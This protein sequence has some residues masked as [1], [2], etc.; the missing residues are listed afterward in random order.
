MNSRDYKAF[1]SGFW[2]HIYNRGHNKGLIFMDRQDYIAF[3]KRLGYILALKDINLKTQIQP[4][5]K[6]CFTIMAY[7]L[8][9]NHFHLLI[10][11]NTEI[12][13]SMLMKKLG[14]SYAKYSN[15]RHGKV[16]DIFQDVFKAKQVDDDS[17]LTYLSAYIHNNPEAPFA[18]EYSSIKEYLDPNKAKFCSVEILLKY[19]DSDP[20]KYRAFVEGYNFKQHKN[21]QH[22]T[23][24]D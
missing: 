7:C 5:D 24:E 12:P 16:G 3:A 2:Y 13:V 21:I 4:L 14:T 15:A 20:Q 11:Q 6:D 18:Y 23:F 9:P 10:R 22:L 19:F 1:R 17:Y 8:M